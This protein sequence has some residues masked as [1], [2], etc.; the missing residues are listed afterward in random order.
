MRADLGFH[1]SRPCVGRLFLSPLLPAEV[2][3][4]SGSCGSADEREIYLS[5]NHRFIGG[6]IL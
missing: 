5:K 6:K 2:V 4:K 3:N 1:V